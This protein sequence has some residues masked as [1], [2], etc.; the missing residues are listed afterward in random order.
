MESLQ[1]F[2]IYNNFHVRPNKARHMFTARLLRHDGAYDLRSDL[3][4]LED[5]DSGER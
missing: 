1:S 5:L 3:A 2:N 4:N